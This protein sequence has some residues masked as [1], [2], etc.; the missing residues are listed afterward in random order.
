MVSAI[1]RQIL[2]SQVVERIQ[3]V[4]QKHPDVQQQYFEIQFS[5]DRHK[6]NKKVNESGGIYGIKVGEEK[7]KKRQKHHPQEQEPAE[8][9]VDGKASSEQKQHD[10]IDI[11][12]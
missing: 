9:V 7:R 5:Q 6:L 8:Q 3:Q 4:Q 1:E 11:K 10:H 12:V 2:Q